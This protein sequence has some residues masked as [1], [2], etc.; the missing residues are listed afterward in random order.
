MKRRNTSSSNARSPVP[1][2]FTWDSGVL[3]KSDRA[4]PPALPVHGTSWAFLQLHP[5]L[6]LS[7]LEALQLLCFPSGDNVHAPNVEVVQGG[8]ATLAAKAAPIKCVC[9]PPLVQSV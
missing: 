1:S 8:G 2:G 7:T 3:I 6:L 5:P 4:A 9:C